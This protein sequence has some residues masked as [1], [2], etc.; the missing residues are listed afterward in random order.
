MTFSTGLFHCFR[1]SDQKIS[2][3]YFLTVNGK[4]NMI[5]G[6]PKMRVFSS[7]I[8]FLS[9]YLVSITCSNVLFRNFARAM[10]KFS[11]DICDVFFGLIYSYHNLIYRNILNQKDVTNV[12]REH[13]HRAS[14]ISKQH[15]CKFLQVMETRYLLRNKI[16]EENT[17]IFGPPMT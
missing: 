1:L 12:T 10:L 6:G 3:L 16:F 17:R 9:K 4:A 7:N 5:I 14:E 13:Q 15:C 8:L 2:C 11:R